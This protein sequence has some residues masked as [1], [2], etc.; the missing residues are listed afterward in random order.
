M[1][2]RALRHTRFGI[3]V[4]AGNQ[5]GA[6]LVNWDLGWVLKADEAERNADFLR[7][8]GRIE[9]ESTSRGRKL[10]YSVAYEL[11]ES[12]EPVLDLRIRLPW[13]LGREWVW[14]RGWEDQL[15]RRDENFY[16][17]NIRHP[18]RGIRAQ[19]RLG[20]GLEAW[21]LLEPTL[22]PD[23]YPKEPVTDSPPAAES[24][25]EPVARPDPHY[26]NVTLPSWVLPGIALLLEWRYPMTDRLFA[27][28]PRLPDAP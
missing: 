15:L 17:L 5:R 6:S 27:G 24:G 20:H 10:V 8:H 22:A 21:S 11:E 18:T 16:H 1:L 12:G 7:E 28:A 9:G 4:R 25:D 2:S 19:M 23:K 13:L 14:V 3:E 26:R